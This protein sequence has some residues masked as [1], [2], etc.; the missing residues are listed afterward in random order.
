MLNYNGTYFKWGLTW[1]ELSFKGGFPLLKLSYNAWVLL[2][3]VAMI[4]WFCAFQD[5]EHHTFW[6][7]EVSCFGVFILFLCMCISLYPISWPTGEESPV[8][9]SELP[10][11]CGFSL[12]RVRRDV[13]LV[14][15][16][17]GCHVRQQV[18]VHKGGKCKVVLQPWDVLH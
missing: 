13:S 14:A 6:L 1:L 8:P 12:K 5:R 7:I 10:A 18:S 9:L 16:Y 15:P 17:N 2:C 4:Q 11:S 3:S